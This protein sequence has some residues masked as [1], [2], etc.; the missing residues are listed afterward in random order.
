MPSRTPRLASTSSK[1]LL[2]NRQPYRCLSYSL[3]LAQSP[4]PPPPQDASQTTHFGF[5]SIPS[6]QKSS[7]VS[8]VFS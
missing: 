8:S 6:S 2:T 5:E 7:R 4:S 1:R 3:R